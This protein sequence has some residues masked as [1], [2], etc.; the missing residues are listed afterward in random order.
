MTSPLRYPGGKSRAIR[1]L[2]QYLHD[3]HSCILSPFFGGG[4]FELSIGIDVLANDLFSPL[5][6]FWNVLKESKETLSEIVKTVPQPFSK[7]L[8][9]LYKDCI[10]DLSYS[11][12]IRAAMF[13]SVNR[14]SFSGSTMSG[15]FSEEASAKRFTTSSIDRLNL[16][17]SR[18]TFSNVDFSVFL[19]SNP[20]GVVYADPPYLIDCKLYGERG[21]L[22]EINHV[23]LRDLL[24]KREDPWIL[25]Y[26]DCTEVRELYRDCQIDSV[27]W[28]YSKGKAGKELVI[29]PWKD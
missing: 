28:K 11:P 21:D 20:R 19:E 6:C 7:E 8:F 3:S 25:S 5:V 22:Q 9:H 26:N 2:R 23:L 1:I 10:Q 18:F 29:T 17:L 15:G 12:L 24:I 16:D 4:S 27:S 13:F 14:S